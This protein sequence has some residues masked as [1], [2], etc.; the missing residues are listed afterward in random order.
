MYP[1]PSLQRDVN[2]FFCYSRL[3]IS[4]GFAILLSLTAIEK[5]VNTFLHENIFFA[6]VVYRF[7]LTPFF[8]QPMKYF[9]TCEVL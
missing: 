9:Y 5:F 4:G 1:K 8:A 7:H 2:K 6:A 3:N